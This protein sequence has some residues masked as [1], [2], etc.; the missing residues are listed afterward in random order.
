M[1]AELKDIV[2]E[3]YASDAIEDRISYSRDMVSSLSGEFIP[4]Y[5]VMPGNVEE[6]QQVVL[7][8]NKYKIPIYPYTFGTNAAGYTLP[9]KG[10]IVLGLKRLN[11][12]IHIDK[13]AMAATIEP[14]VTWR[15]LAAKANKV[16][17]Q[18]TLPIG[19]YTG[20][21]IGS[22]VL[23]NITGHAA[24]FGADRVISLEAVL[25]NGEIIRTASSAMPDHEKLNPY[26]RYAYGPDITGLFRGS[27]GA[28]GIVTKVVY[29][30]Y[31]LGEVEKH[32]DVGF[33]DLSSLLRALKYIERHD[34]T[35]YSIFFD[36][37]LMINACAPDIKQLENVSER[38][39][40]GNL[41]PKWLL[42]L[43]L[44]GPSQLVSLH[45][46]MILEEAHTNK[47]QIVDLESYQVINGK[48][49]DLIPGASL[50]INRMYEPHGAAAS[51]VAVAPLYNIEKLVM[52]AESLIEEFDIRDP[53]S[54]APLDLMVEGYPYDRG[55]NI[56]LEL[57]LSFDPMDK[58]ATAKIKEARRAWVKRMIPLG[59]SLMMLNVA[60]TR[61]LMPTYSNL[62]RQ[63]K[64][65][66]DPHD[67]LA[68]YKLLALS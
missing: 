50:V 62:L 9:I 1:I 66:L 8:A 31:P 64:Q 39:N 14:G 20:S 51:I 15:Y 11:R 17:L 49:N 23:W 61:M 46:E 34:I 32:V 59:G 7:L 26:L 42:T 12:I 6:I 60:Y 57:E 67:I 63:I 54:G 27:F 24:R 41:F 43:G 45:E 28:F 53:Q 3:Q 48:K 68:P 10:G 37:N 35:K 38:E 40:I 22:F 65:A 13:D 33:E 47:G 21:P 58:E 55:R 29:Q 30:L 25:P 5:V 36:R 4:E 18:P 44:S 56:Y 16:G 19:P 52:L 2:G